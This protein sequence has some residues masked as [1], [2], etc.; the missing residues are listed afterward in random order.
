MDLK[1]STPQGIIEVEAT[2][3]IDASGF[4]S[5]VSRKL[6]YVSNWKRYGIGAEY[7]CYCDKMDQET[8]YLMVGANILSRI[9]L[10]FSTV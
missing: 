4:S 5:F 3:V 7:E 9:C 10:D 2:L 1:V 8:L 6:G